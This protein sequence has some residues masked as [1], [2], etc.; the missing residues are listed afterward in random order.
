VVES[1]KQ[2]INELT[3]CDKGDAEIRDTIKLRE[4]RPFV[5]KDQAYM[6]SK[7]SIFNRVIGDSGFELEFALVLG[8]VQ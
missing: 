6:V 2:A 8:A 5:V 1:F 3:V 7:K 4:T